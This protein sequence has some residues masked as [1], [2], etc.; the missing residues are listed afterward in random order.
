MTLSAANTTQMHIVNR[1]HP[2]NKLPL[3]KHCAPKW[4]TPTAAIEKF[5]AKILALIS[6]KLQ[7]VQASATHRTYA[8]FCT[9]WNRLGQLTKCDKK[10][11]KINV[12]GGGSG[13]RTHGELA[14]TP[15]FKTG[16]LNRSAIPPEP[17]LYAGT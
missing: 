13:I 2:Q 12:Y 8:K 17:A 5:K 6:I 4:E 11:N 7:N 16:A 10:H 1:G 14:P 3:P 9:S 15:V